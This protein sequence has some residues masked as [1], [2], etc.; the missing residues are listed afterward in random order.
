MKNF[1]LN[2]RFREGTRVRYNG[3]D[4]KLSGKVGKIRKIYGGWV[5]VEFEFEGPIGAKK[6]I[7]SVERET[8]EII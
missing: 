4:N 7:V 1:W 6:E 5:D 8:L 3:L 2:R